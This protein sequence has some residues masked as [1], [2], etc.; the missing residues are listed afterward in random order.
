LVASAEVESALIV[1]G[2]DLANLSDI[3]IDIEALRR[4][5]VIVPLSGEPSYGWIE[6]V[7][8]RADHGCA[9]G[10]VLATGSSGAGSLDF[11][12]LTALARRHRIPVP[13]APDDPS[14]VWVQMVKAIREEREHTWNELRDRHR[15]ST[16]R[17]GLKR[18]LRR[19]ARQVGGSAVLLDR[20]GMPVH[21]FPE[22]PADALKQAAAEIERVVTGEIRAAAADLGDGVVHI[23]SIGAEETGAALVVVRKERFSPAVRGLVA[24]VSRLL[25][26]CWRADD[27]SRRSSTCAKQRS[28]ERSTTGSPRSSDPPRWRRPLARS[29]SRAEQSN[30]PNQAAAMVI[31]AKIADC[32]QRLARYRGALDAGA[33][34]LEVT[35]WINE[36]KAE[37]TR[38]EGERRAL[39]TT[40]RMNRDEISTVLTELGDLARVVVQAEAADKAKLYRE[41]GLKLTYRPQKQ[42]VEAKVTPDRDMCKRLVSEGRVDS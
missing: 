18:L 12:A 9:A 35:Q 28:S 4:V 32:D 36:A 6:T 2:V 40:R 19:L 10:V 21:A 27:L 26:L 11:K 22:I 39:H 41:L 30:D 7:V 20:M 14:R 5:L 16:R 24:D 33:D 3:D 13:V 1:S 15:E 8:R 37:R 25:A 29:P 17:D 23:Q 34:P 38:A 42:L 31:K